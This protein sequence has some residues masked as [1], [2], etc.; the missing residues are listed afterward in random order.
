VETTPLQRNG[1]R[2][3]LSL[4]IALIYAVLGASWI[5]FSDQ[6]AAMISSTPEALTHIAMIKGWLYVLL[7]AS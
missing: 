2:E 5:F 1:H 3:R 6:M 4:K 7:T